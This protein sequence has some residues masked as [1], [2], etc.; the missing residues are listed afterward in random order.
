MTHRP[1]SLQTG[2]M[3]AVIGFVSLILDA[4]KP[5]SANG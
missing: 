5:D 2:L 3:T 4:R 1:M